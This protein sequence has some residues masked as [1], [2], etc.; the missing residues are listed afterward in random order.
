M[1]AE[2]EGLVPPEGFLIADRRGP[3]SLH[4]GPFYHRPAENR[5]E[6]GFFA[7]KRHCNGMGIVH[8]GMLA[9]FID[10]MLGH[11]VAADAKSAAV[12]IHLSLD[13]L[14][15]ARAGEWVQGEAQ[16]TRRARDIAFAESR[17]FVGAKDVVRATAVFKLMD[18]HRA[19]G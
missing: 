2:G 17:A 14:S 1:T 11:A 10:G 19:R 9:T 7:L 4:N 16:V 12:T 3:F 6:Q 13:Y 5:I 18:R 15:M 8:G